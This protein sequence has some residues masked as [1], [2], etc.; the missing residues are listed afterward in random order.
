MEPE[1]GEVG[2][3]TVQRIPVLNLGVGMGAAEGQK[4]ARHQPVEVPVL[5]L[6]VVLVLLA[7]KVLKVKEA[8]GLGLADG[9]QTVQDGDGVHGDTKG[10]IPKR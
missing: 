6:L 7:V 9:V 4:P 2:L 5:D 10:G 1:V 8:G 3:G